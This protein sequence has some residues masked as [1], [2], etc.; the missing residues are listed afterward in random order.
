MASEKPLTYWLRNPGDPLNG[1][2]DRQ[3]K[4][5]AADEIERLERELAAHELAIETLSSAR[6]HEEHEAREG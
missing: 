5:M 6:S 3:L 1:F 2:T 4:E